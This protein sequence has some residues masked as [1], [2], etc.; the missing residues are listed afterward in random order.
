[1]FQNHLDLPEKQLPGQ[2]VLQAAAVVH[3]QA[4]PPVGWV[5]IS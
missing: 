4:A 3:P 1:L 5:K 2:Q